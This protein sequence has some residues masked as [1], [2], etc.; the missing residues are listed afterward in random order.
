MLHTVYCKGLLHSCP[1][2]YS[3]NTVL[4]LVFETITRVPAAL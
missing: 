2:Q 4:N 1:V 3:T